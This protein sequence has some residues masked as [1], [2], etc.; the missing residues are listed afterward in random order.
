MSICVPGTCN[1]MHVGIRGFL[2]PLCQVELRAQLS[3]LEQQ[4]AK[5]RESHI[6]D[7]RQMEEVAGKKLQGAQQE[8]QQV[9]SQKDSLQEEVKELRQE[10]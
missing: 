7:L 9:S 2:P 5:E 4:L 3:K 6:S 10:R 8:L 1:N